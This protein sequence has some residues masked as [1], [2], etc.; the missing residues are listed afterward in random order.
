MNPSAQLVRAVFNF[1]T[2]AQAVMLRPAHRRPSSRLLL[3]QGCHN[4]AQSSC[5]MSQHHPNF[6]TECSRKS[7]ESRWTAQTHAALCAE[8]QMRAGW[9]QKA[10][11]VSAEVSINH[12]PMRKF[13][14]G[15]KLS[16]WN[17]IT[18]RR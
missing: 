13:C 2:D 4:Y 6:L 18:E 11:S 3:C 9:A 7:T 5:S 15:Q 8:A 14:R 12:G 17:T 16:G 10:G 1:S